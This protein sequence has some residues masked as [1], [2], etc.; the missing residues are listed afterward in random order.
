MRDLLIGVLPVLGVVVG[1]VLQ[2]MF[3]RSKEREG[4]LALLRHQSYADFLKAVA[5]AARSQA[6]DVMTR[7]ADAKARM[8]VYG[9]NAVLEKLAVFEESGASLT[10]DASKRAFIMMTEQMRA[11]NSSNTLRLQDG[12]LAWVLFG[13]SL[14]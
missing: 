9:S 1:A 13:K 2:H 3:A 14:N 8:A 5:S 11:E 10:N 12:V 4:Q 6:A 7:A